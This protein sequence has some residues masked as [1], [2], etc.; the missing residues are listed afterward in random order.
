MQLF[1]HR[2]KQLEKDFILDGVALSKQ[3]NDETGRTKP[4]LNIGIPQY[5]ALRDR[6]CRHFFKSSLKSM[7]GSAEK[8]DV[9]DIH[10]VFTQ[11]SEAQRYLDD[12]KKVGAGEWFLPI[13]A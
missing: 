12:R 2:V 5:S 6:G 1:P 9:T 3:A 7:K 4:S 8:V 13:I 11:K 10:T